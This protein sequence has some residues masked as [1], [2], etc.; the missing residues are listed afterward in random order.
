MRYFNY[1]KINYHGQIAW[2]AAEVTVNLTIGEQ[3]VNLPARVTGVLKKEGD[4]RLIKQGHISTPA[5]EN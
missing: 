4:E 1:K 3:K 5:A 2:L